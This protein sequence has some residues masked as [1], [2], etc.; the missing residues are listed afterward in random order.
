MTNSLGIRKYDYIEFYV[1]SAKMVAYW[2]SKAMG[3][4][5][6]AYKGP[7]TGCRDRSSYLLEKDQIKFVVSSPLQP[8][9]SDMQLFL[10]THGD[11]V[12]RFA[13][14]V[15]NVVKAFKYAVEHGAIP[16][17]APE[18]LKENNNGYVE[19]A[20]IRL[21]DD[22]EIV[23]LNR[24][25][26][27]GKFLP[28]YGNPVQEMD[29]KCK[30]T[31]LSF[32]DHIVG[33][34]RENEMNLWANYFNKSLD[35]ET[36]VDFGPGDISTKYSA[37][38]SKVVRS[39]DNRVK[40]PINEPFEGVRMSQIE[41]FIKEYYGTGVQH[42]AIQ[43]HDIL[44]S[45]EALRDNGV[46]FLKVPDTYYDSMREANPNI[47]ENIDDL[48]KLGILMDFEGDGYLLQLFMKPIF[49]RPT[50]FFEIIQ[51]QGKS[52]GFGQGNFQALFEA[53]ELDQAKRGN[54][55]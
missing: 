4:K 21:Y 15:D 30:D 53:I 52:E 45:I 43:T 22:S 46:E 11:G 54:L 39:K 8:S 27:G 1:G 14:E 40:N 20:A 34:V 37:L 9:T 10:Q 2:F 25:N 55:V 35:F 3:L 26:Y 47:K 19:T 51:R 42:I 7:E 6:T 50:F 24:D 17:K 33:N 23:L 12:K 48:Q 29:I 44:S 36:F 18:L 32:V 41:E 16:Q 5:I 38:L 49:D 13:L 28:Q 31:G